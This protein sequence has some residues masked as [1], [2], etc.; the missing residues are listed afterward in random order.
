MGQTRGGYYPTSQYHGVYSN[1]TYVNQPYQRAWNQMDKPRLP[2]LAML[3]LPDL[4]RLTNDLVSHDSTWS[5]VPP[6]IPLDIPKFEGKSGEDP[7]EHI[8]MFHLWFSLNLL[9]HDS[10]HL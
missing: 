6:K 4:S 3:N 5:V 7:G 10:I 1:Q 2:F 8:T 9:N